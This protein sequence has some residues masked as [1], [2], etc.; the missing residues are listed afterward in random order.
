[1]TKT[2][3]HCMFGDNRQTSRS[4][5]APRYRNVTTTATSS[6][7]KPFFFSLLQVKHPTGNNNSNNAMKEKEEGD[8]ELPLNLYEIQVHDGAAVLVGMEN[9]SLETSEAERI[10][11]ERVVR[12]Q[13]Q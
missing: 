4:T 10:A 1:M 5:H 7:E 6:E 11:V 9:W 8:D 13:P 12:E 3:H 2:F